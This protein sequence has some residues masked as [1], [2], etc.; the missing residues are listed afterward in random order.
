MSCGVSYHH[1]KV[2]E[3]HHQPDVART[4]FQG[5]SIAWIGFA[6]VSVTRLGAEYVATK[7]QMRKMYGLFTYMKGEQW[8]HEQGEMAG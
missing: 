8:P 2:E 7:P 3:S 5:T 4:P 6:N 1:G